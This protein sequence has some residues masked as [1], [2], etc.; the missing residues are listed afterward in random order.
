STSLC[1][2]FQKLEPCLASPFLT[3]RHL[4]PLYYVAPEM[5]PRFLLAD[6]VTEW[7]E[8]QQIA[9]ELLTS[10]LIHPLRMRSLNFLAPTAAALLVSIAIAQQHQRRSD[11]D[12]EA[13]PQS[14]PAF[15]RQLA[16]DL[17]KIRDAALQDDFA[18]QQLAHL[19]ENI[20]ARPVGSRQTVAAVQYVADELRKL[21]LEVR[22][23]EVRAPRWV[24][25]AERAEL[26]DY[27]GQVPGT[28]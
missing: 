21:G 6:S 24:R 5:G 23:E 22:L 4:L 1:K 11:Y 14:G 2:P 20:G 12:A 26:V 10:K 19:T 3:S 7:P 17:V 15:P 28:A 18:Y 27:P 25:G 16:S 9:D 13:Q 8:Q